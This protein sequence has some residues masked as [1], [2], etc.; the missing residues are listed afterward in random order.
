MVVDDQEANLRKEVGHQR[1]VDDGKEACDGQKAG[2]L[3][4]QKDDPQIVSDKVFRSS[5]KN[6]IAGQ[7]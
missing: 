5:K 1:K 2:C 4:C 3:Q 7:R 6:V